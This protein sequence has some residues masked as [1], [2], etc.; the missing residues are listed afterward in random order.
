MSDNEL[1]ERVALWKSRKTWDLLGTPKIIEEA[2]W[3]IDHLLGAFELA[4]EEENQCC[5]D[6]MCEVC[7][8]QHKMA[9]CSAQDCIMHENWHIRWLN[10]ALLTANEIRAGLQTENSALKTR[11]AGRT[12]YHDNAAVEV[13][14]A[15]YREVLEKLSHGKDWEDSSI[16]RAVLQE[17]QG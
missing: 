13:E 4:E 8:Y 15:R 11:P 16:A 7:E 17:V 14:N 6:D 10:D 12:Y 1:K 2:E 3:C 9:S 5:Y